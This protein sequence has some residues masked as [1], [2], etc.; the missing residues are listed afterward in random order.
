MKKTHLK[1]VCFLTLLASLVSGGC[2]FQRTSTSEYWIE[3][4]MKYEMTERYDHAAK[5]YTRALEIDPKNEN[6]YF[7][8]AEAHTKNGDWKT[9]IADYTRA[10]RINPKN[11]LLYYSRGL[12][13]L[14]T[15][16]YAKVIRD[17]KK[18]RDIDPANYQMFL[19][20]MKSEITKRKNG[21]NRNNRNNRN[22]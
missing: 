20:D 18:A 17:A 7:F 19:T 11:V 12:A 10:I 15:E 1:A 16:E 13:Y 8:R 6:L 5:A 22:N 9:G 3:K 14:E 21:N 2:L 4:A